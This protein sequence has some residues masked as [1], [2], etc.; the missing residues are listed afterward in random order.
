M[1]LLFN[2]FEIAALI[3]TYVFFCLVANT[4]FQKSQRYH[5]T[6]LIFFGTV[7]VILGLLPPTLL[8]NTIFSPLSMLLS[9]L[10]LLCCFDG[11]LWK[12]LTMLILFNIVDLL[13]SNIITNLFLLS[14]HTT[15]S[16]LFTKGSYLRLLYLFVIYMTEFAIVYYLNHFHTFSNVLTQKS[17][18]ISFLFFF[19]DFIVAFLLHIILVSFAPKLPYL[20]GI[21]LSIALCLIATT[22]MGLYLLKA[23]EQEQ[24]NSIEMALLKLQLQQQKE[25]ILESEEHYQQSRILKHDI[26][27]LLLNYRILLAEGKQQQ[28]MDNITEFIS[29][30]PS[31]SDIIYTDNQL[32][33]ALLHAKQQRCLKENIIFE[34]H[35]VLDP[36]YDNIQVMILILNL[37]DNAIEASSKEPAGNRL[38]RFEIIQTEQNIS[39]VSQNRISSSVL[40]HN[41]DLLSKKPHSHEHGLGLKSIS[42]LTEQYHGMLDIYEEQNLFCVHVL[43]PY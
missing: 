1:S 3:L 14:G 38:I 43:L 27:H 11:T 34:Q 32:L 9:L 15:A 22:L 8:P 40:E 7:E 29:D 24:E 2:L 26:K 30:A 17:L 20:Y 19:C 25:L 31:S 36:L 16:M 35:I 4:F 39:I 23:Q 42:L 41:P 5:V 21:C 28:V 10:V 18:W 6:Y 13:I 37:L 12:K 33:N